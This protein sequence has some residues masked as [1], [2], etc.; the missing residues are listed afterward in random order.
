MCFWLRDEE[1]SADECALVAKEF[2]IVGQ[3]EILEEMHA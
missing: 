1:Q 2:F 3:D